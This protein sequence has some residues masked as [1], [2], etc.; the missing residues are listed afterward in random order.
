MDLVGNFKD[1]FLMKQLI[2]EPACSDT[3]LLAMHMKSV[4]FL[5]CQAQK[6]KTFN[7]LK[8]G[9]Y[10]IFKLFPFHYKNVFDVSL[11]QLT[12]CNIDLHKFSRMIKL[13]FCICKIKGA[14]QR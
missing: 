5:C 11:S 4:N 9:M 7:S 14:D 1:G 12:C 10:R 6:D 3:Q 8:H 2:F 13:A